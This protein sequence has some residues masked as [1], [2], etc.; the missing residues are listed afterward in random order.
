MTL[1]KHE[2]AD[3]WVH[4]AWDSRH[5]GFPIGRLLPRS[6]G[7]TELASSVESVNEAGIRCLYWLADRT[8]KNTNAANLTGFKLVSSRTVLERPLPAGIRSDSNGAEVR[9]GLDAD[10][11]TLRSLAASSHQNT[12][13]YTDSSFPR[14]LADAMYGAWIDRGHRDPFQR[15]LVTGP[16]GGPVG[17]IICEVDEAHTQGSIGLVAV[18]KQNQGVGLGTVLLANALTWLSNQ[19]ARTVSVVT[20]AENAA[21]L[22]LYRTSDFTVKDVAV[23]FH[24]W[25]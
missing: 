14:D 17:Y 23:W 21:A 11:E 19:G 22:R 7:V 12:R 3:V 10:L 2:H 5:F 15:L 20:Q 13:F 9:V 6:L 4:L 8:P 25:F 24:R 16:V 1:P 18:A